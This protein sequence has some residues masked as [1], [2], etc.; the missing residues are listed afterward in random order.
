MAI[1]RVVVMTHTGNDDKDNGNGV[2]VRIFN[3]KTNEIYL[4]LQNY[5]VGLTYQRGDD[6]G[7]DRPTT[8]PIAVS[9]LEDT[10]LWVEMNGNDG[11]WEAAF[12]VTGFVDA[13]T[14][15]TLMQRSGFYHFESGK[16]DAVQLNFTYRMKSPRA[17]A[18]ESRE[19]FR[20]VSSPATLN[21]ARK[22]TVRK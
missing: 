22:E 9:D 2:T 17:L 16:S 18:R 14:Q 1:N 12:S 13:T 20:S 6:N 8:H 3:T 19:R 11:N 15:I 21:E 10:V 7:W 5:G 4:E